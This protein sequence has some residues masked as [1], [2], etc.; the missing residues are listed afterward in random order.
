MKYLFLTLVMAFS[1]QFASAQTEKMTVKSSV[2]CE[3]CKE[4]IEEG[5]TYVDGVK[6]VRVNVDKNEIF[7]KY[8]AS[9]ISEKEV[10]QKINSLGYTADDMK[11]TEA[12][13]KTLHDCCRPGAVCE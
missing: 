3:M 4:T 11:P 9:V 1:I 6:A 8:K 7:V 2:I 12:Q 5:L 13:I 10:K